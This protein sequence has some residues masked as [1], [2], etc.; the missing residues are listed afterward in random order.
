VL[1]S[2]ASLAVS[3]MAIWASLGVAAQAGFWVRLVDFFML[4]YGVGTAVLLILAWL[5]GRMWQAHTT[6]ALATSFFIAIVV[7][8]FD[9]GMISGLEFVFLLAVALILFVNWLAVR[10]VL[11][12]L[13]EE[14][15]NPSLQRTPPG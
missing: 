11:R 14:S 13:V 4:A 15:P 3:G 6:A 5:R 10:V 1:L 9:S 12:P 8:S 2:V 7:A